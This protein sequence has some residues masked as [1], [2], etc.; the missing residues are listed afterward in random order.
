MSDIIMDEFGNYPDDKE[1]ETVTEGNVGNLNHKP[2]ECIMACIYCGE[3]FRT[4]LVAHRNDGG[5]ITGYLVTCPECTEYTY[6]G[7]YQ[8][9]AKGVSENSEVIHER[10]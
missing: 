2:D 1:G 9:R 6:G 5:Y 8:F 3:T 10:R 4:S 7:T